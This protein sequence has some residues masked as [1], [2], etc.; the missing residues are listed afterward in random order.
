MGLSQEPLGSLNPPQREEDINEIL[1]NEIGTPKS[2]L[3][4]V[5]WSPEPSLFPPSS[6]ARG[7]S[8]GSWS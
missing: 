4:C 3:L 8:A 5:R 2:L 6:R 7:S 1:T